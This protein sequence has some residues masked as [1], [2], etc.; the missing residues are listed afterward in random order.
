[1]RLTIITAGILTV[2]ASSL[3][4]EAAPLRMYYGRGLDDNAAILSPDRNLITRE[5]LQAIYAREPPRKDS[6]HIG[7]SAPLVRRVDETGSTNP[8]APPANSANPD[9]P[10]PKY[11]Q[12]VRTA[13][14]RP[15]VD[16]VTPD[17]TDEDLP[18]PYK[19]WAS[20]TDHAPGG[21]Y[22]PP[23]GADQP[24]SAKGRVKNKV[25][26]P[27]GAGYAEPQ[28]VTAHEGFN[29][30]REYPPRAWTAHRMANPL[31]PH[32]DSSVV[33]PAKSEGKKPKGEDSFV[34]KGVAGHINPSIVLPGH[35][36]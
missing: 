24:S 12:P 7:I 8:P 16:R 35:L 15:Y 14:P 22:P 10:P 13:L 4:A 23:P 9:S 3:E 17:P 2:L 6:R 11:N 32:I 26:A 1:M 18:P 5:I 36:P 28:G 27:L 21:T 29:L 25:S 19:H 30:D 31:P 34:V 33:K 20:A